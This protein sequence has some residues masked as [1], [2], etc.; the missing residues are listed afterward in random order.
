MSRYTTKDLHACAAPRRRLIPRHLFLW[1]G[2]AAFAAVWLVPLLFVVFTSLK[3]RHDLLLGSPFAL[4]HRLSLDNYIEAWRRGH[5]ADYGLNSLVIALIKVPVGLIISSLAAFA[6]TR[7]RFSFRKGIYRFIIVGTLI[8]VQIALS[9]LF[10]L[11]LKAGLLNTY[12]GVLLPYI[13]F[14]IPYQVFLLSG[15]FFR[16]SS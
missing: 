1:T 7:M 9:P 4:P 16:H 12:A 10:T 11:M 3:S 6:L 8:P 5:L 2:L 15:F 13:A 14:G